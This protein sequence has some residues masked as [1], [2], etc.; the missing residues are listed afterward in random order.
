[1]P[2]EYT[3][4]S[5]H[6]SILQKTE[7]NSACLQGPPEWHP[8]PK[9]VRETCAKAAAHAKSEGVSIE[10]LAIQYAFQKPNVST[11][12]IGMATRDE[13]CLAL[14]FPIACH[15]FPQLCLHCTVYDIVPDLQL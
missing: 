4:C 7:Q 1:M 6:F 14:G 13:V 3:G 8:A 12:L 10:R 15:S 5:K 9:E 11:V 2:N